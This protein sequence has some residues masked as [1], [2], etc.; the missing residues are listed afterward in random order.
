MTL[1]QVNSDGSPVLLMI[2]LILRIV[3]IL[4]CVNKAK[5][6]NRSEG[7]W[8]FFGFLM[9]IVAM[10]WVHCMKPKVTWENQANKS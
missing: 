7:G 3:G 9:P 10:I 6:L 4:V 1:L 2:Q 5:E 8:G